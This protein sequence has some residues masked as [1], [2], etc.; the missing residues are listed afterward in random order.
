MPMA[1]RVVGNNGVILGAQMRCNDP[2]NAKVLSRNASHA[3]PS[4]VIGF[5]CPSLVKLS[6]ANRVSSSPSCPFESSERAAQA[7]GPRPV[8]SHRGCQLV[9]V[10]LCPRIPRIDSRL[11]AFRRGR[12]GISALDR[13]ILPVANGSNVHTAGVKEDSICT[14]SSEDAANV[15]LGHTVVE[16]AQPVVLVPE[17]DD[18]PPAWKGLST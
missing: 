16:A 8:T 6:Q 1:K 12:F 7:K 4:H 13:Y 11:E 15:H 9:L 14:I 18:H 5:D 2:P 3:M 10:R 17:L